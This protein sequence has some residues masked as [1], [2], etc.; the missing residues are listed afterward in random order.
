M[1]ECICQRGLADIHSDV[2]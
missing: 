1:I 2:H